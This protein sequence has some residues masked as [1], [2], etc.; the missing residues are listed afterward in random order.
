MS[1]TAT[2]SALGTS[3]TFSVNNNASPPAAVH[4]RTYQ[5]CIPCRQRK[6][7]CDLG[8]VDA[9]HDP[10]CVRCRREKKNCYFTPTRRKR[11]PGDEDEGETAGDVNEE[12]QAHKR[13]SITDGDLPDHG[14][15]SSQ[16]GGR[17][18]ASYLSQLD[19]PPLGEY[20]SSDANTFQYPRPLYLS[21]RSGTSNTAEGQE[22]TN[23]TATALFR[24]PINNPKDALHVLIEAAGRT[25]DM[26]RQ[27]DQANVTS[28]SHVRKT[29]DFA[30]PARANSTGRDE[31]LQ[32]IDPAIANSSRVMSP[33]QDGGVQEAL[34]A[35]S[36]VRFVRGML[37]ACSSLLPC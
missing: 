23:E 8:P 14:R 33:S 30:R 16:F 36:R 19:T 17:R 9:P 5:A 15:R 12:D 7:R 37:T 29:T 3:S 22:V 20:N 34:R 31:R 11:K 32:V 26:I 24:D 2:Q 4:K 10:P 18:P 35:W 6:V 1:T 25:E 28:S 27:N 13:R 21:P